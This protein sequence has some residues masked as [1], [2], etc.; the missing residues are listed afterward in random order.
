MQDILNQ[1]AEIDRAGTT[2]RIRVIGYAYWVDFGPST[3]PRFHIVNKQRRCSCPSKETCPA[4]E[5]VAEYLRNGGQRAPDPMPICPICGAETVRDRNWDGKYTKELGWRC[6]AGGLR[7]FLEAKAER[8]KE[9][10]RRNQ[11]AVSEHESAADR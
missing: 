9:A 2:A 7:H 1:K 4:V 8:I 10:L 11:T 5:A 6:T 3:Q